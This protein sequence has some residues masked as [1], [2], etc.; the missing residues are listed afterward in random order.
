MK[1]KLEHL[2]LKRI[3]LTVFLTIKVM[4]FKDLEVNWLPKLRNLMAKFKNLETISQ[5]FK[6]NLIVKPEKVHQIQKI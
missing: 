5:T 4:N 2:R 3:L 6:I 1:A